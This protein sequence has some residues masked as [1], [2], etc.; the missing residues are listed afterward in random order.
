MA[1]FLAN[2][3]NFPLAFSIFALGFS[4]FALIYNVRHYIRVDREWRR[5]RGEK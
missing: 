1:D 5:S 4:I 3:P 2:N